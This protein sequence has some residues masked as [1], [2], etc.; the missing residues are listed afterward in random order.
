MLVSQEKLTKTL[1]DF[2][3]TFF[4]FLIFRYFLAEILLNKRPSFH[5]GVVLSMCYGFAYLAASNL[6]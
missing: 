6:L 4:I 2:T 3:I 1:R 5:R